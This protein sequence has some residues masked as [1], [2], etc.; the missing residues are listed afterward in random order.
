MGSI[1][2]S[3]RTLYELTRLKVTINLPN[4]PTSTIQQFSFFV[5]VVVDAESDFTRSLLLSQT[6]DEYCDPLSQESNVTTVYE[7]G[8]V[9]GLAKKQGYL[10]HPF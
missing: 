8:T 2:V 7:S 6:K 9:Y 4:L 3:P 5:A 1:R 10:R